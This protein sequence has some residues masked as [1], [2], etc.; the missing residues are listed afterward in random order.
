MPYGRPTLVQRSLFFSIDGAVSAAVNGKDLSST[1][2]FWQDAEKTALN[3]DSTK[4]L[5]EFVFKSANRFR[6][7]EV[8]EGVEDFR[9]VWKT[10]EDA[11]IDYNRFHE[12]R[13]KVT[14]RST[15]CLTLVPSLKVKR[16]SYCQSVWRLLSKRSATREGDAQ[17]P[18]RK[19]AY[20]YLNTP[21]KTK[22]MKQIS[23]DMKRLR[24][25]NERLKR[26][27]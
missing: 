12:P 15:E 5:S 17:T 18:E 22:R 14:C 19:K 11:E 27:V 25:S 9:E 7:H 20:K 13:F 4:E 26:K 23:K 10:A 2:P 1:H 3:E 16:C 6:S 8:C 21:Q 24:A